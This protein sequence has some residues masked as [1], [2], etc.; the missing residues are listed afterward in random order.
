MLNID[1]SILNLDKQTLSKVMKL[2]EAEK[3]PD[4]VIEFNDIFMRF[5]RTLTTDVTSGRCVITETLTDLRYILDYHLTPISTQYT[6]Q[7]R[8]PKTNII[9]VRFDF[10]NTIRHTNNRNEPN[11]YKVVGSHIH[12][13]ADPDKHT[14]KNVIPISTID[15]FPN[16]KIIVDA[17]IAFLQYTRVNYQN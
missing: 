5:V 13:Y 16:I 3:H 4:N 2:I 7:L 14:L 15:N 17:F 1:Y 6:I 9:L 11:E 8:N 12:I 10:G